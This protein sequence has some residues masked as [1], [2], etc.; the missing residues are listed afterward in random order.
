MGL[1]FED[2]S[3]LETATGGQRAWLRRAIAAANKQ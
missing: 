3:G 2:L 1:Q